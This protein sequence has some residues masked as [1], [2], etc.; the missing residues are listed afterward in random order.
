LT[1]WKN[2]PDQITKANKIMKVDQVGH[3]PWEN[4]MNLVEVANQ[5]E[6]INIIN[7]WKDKLDH[8]T[9]IYI[10][11]PSHKQAITL[12]IMINT[13]ELMVLLEKLKSLLNLL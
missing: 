5:Q 1:D 10:G 3:I 6:Y 13:C 9:A 11:V 12:N 7:A 4:K 8:H 2:R